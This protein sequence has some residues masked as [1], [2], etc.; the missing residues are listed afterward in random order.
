MNRYHKQTTVSTE[1]IP[2]S[3]FQKMVWSVIESGICL[4]SSPPFLWAG[5]QFGTQL[6]LYSLF[7]IFSP[8]LDAVGNSEVGSKKPM[9][10]NCEGGDKNLSPK[11]HFRDIKSSNNRAFFESPVTAVCTS[12][13]HRSGMAY[14]YC[15]ARTLHSV[16]VSVVNCFSL[17]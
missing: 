9:T 6:T 17:F 4:Q 7:V 11:R 13:G 1:R 2:Y 10:R 16:F 15:L 5:L 14:A 8:V 3:P 12:D